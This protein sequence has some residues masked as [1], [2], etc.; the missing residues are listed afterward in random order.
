MKKFLCVLLTLTTLLSSMVFV[1]SAAEDEVPD[2]VLINSLDANVDAG[3]TADKAN[4]KEGSASV[5]RDFSGTVGAATMLMQ[6]A[7]APVDGTKHATL[8]FDMYV[9]DPA[10]LASVQYEIEL[11]SAATS[12][13]QE[14]RRVNKT[15]PALKKGWN[16]VSLPLSDFNSFTDSGVSGAEN[17]RPVDGSAVT[18]FRIYNITSFVVDGTLT[19]KFDN[20]RFADPRGDIVTWSTN[21]YSSKGPGKYDAGGALNTNNIVQFPVDISEMDYFVFDYQATGKGRDVALFFEIGSDDD[22][23]DDWELQKQTSFTQ[24]EKVEYGFY[25]GDVEGWSTIAIPISTFGKSTNKV[26]DESCDLTNVCRVR[27]FANGCTLEEGDSF[28]IKNIRFVN[29][30]TVESKEGALTEGSYSLWTGNTGGN[31]NWKYIPTSRVNGGLALMRYAHSGN[32]FDVN[33]TAV[34]STEGGYNA[35]TF[36]VYVNN[37]SML[38]S[39]HYLGDS[40]CYLQSTNNAK[41][42][43]TNEQ[44]IAAISNP[45]EGWNK[46]TLKLSDGKDSGNFDATAIKRFYFRTK[47]SAEIVGNKWQLILGMDDVRLVD[48]SYIPP[49]DGVIGMVQKVFTAYKL[50]AKIP[51]L[52]KLF[53]V[54]AD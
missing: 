43:W 46:V 23:M 8:K 52:S 1:V 12:D 2:E 17:T 13:K 41:L 20:V 28:T 18:W 31:T 14:V 34:D 5:T 38:D 45:T 54:S 10:P 53:G 26:P 32:T 37:L 7:F 33:F 6:V 30:D 49:A 3:W 16:T 50:L 15:L 9:S 48:T 42:S 39:K 27:I 44:V 29:A 25:A 47:Y 22:K 51:F 11:T 24:N 4:K 21:T 36:W 19:V 40:E 35:V